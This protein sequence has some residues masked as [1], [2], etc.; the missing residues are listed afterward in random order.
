LIILLNSTKT[1]DL[2]AEVPV[3][4]ATTTPT[5]LAQ[6][7]TLAAPLAKVSL[8]RLESLL[9]VKG[10]LAD[11]TRADLALWGTAGRA[12]RPA[13]SAFTGL[14]YKYLDAPTLTKIHWNRAQKSVRILSGLYGLL[15][16]W[17][18]VEAY[19]LEMG[20]K[21]KPPGAKNLTA[22]WRGPV[23]E[24]LNRELK[25]GEPVL[26]VAALEYVRAVE[27]GQLNGP[28]IQPVFKERL[29]DGRL[30][31]SPVHA[32]MARGALVRHAL[33]SGARRPADLLG[34]AELGWEAAEEPP[35]AGAWLFVRDRRE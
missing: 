11:R 16:P 31:T 30:K 3:R 27:S 22:F 1:M 18:E 35:P 20:S 29:P 15:R 17:D 24:A 2:G 33:T 14:V 26:S 25:P 12:R 5:H 28:I 9:G 7:Q 34:F 13:L 4:L 6:A 10:K 23:T 19:R 8:A 21:V 32:K